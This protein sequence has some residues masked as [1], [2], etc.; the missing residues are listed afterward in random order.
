MNRHV[1][2]PNP[3]LSGLDAGP[4]SELAD[5]D[6]P[7]SL[8]ATRPGEQPLR[9]AVDAAMRRY[10]DHLDGGTATDLYAMVMAEVEAPLLAAVLDYTQGNQT[11]AAELLGLNRGTLRKKLKQHDL[12]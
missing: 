4:C 6:G 2:N 9:E 1:F 8:A 11:R 3:D 12:I 7:A 5:P 10:F